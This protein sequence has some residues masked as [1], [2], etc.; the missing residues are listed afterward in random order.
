MVTAGKD[1]LPERGRKEVEV[2]VLYTGGYS[3]THYR[4]G[5]FL[6]RHAV[7]EGTKDCGVKEAGS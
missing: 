5:V 1:R 2:I 6:G 3:G 7:G 4:R